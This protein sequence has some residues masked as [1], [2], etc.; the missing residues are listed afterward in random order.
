MAPALDLLAFGRRRETAAK[1]RRARRPALKSLESRQLLS[2][3][4]VADFPVKTASSWPTG[5]TAG[6]D[7]NLWFTENVSGGKVGEIN[8]T[9]HAVTEFPIPTT[10]SGPLGITAGPDGNLWFTEG[11]TDKIGMINPTTHAITE[12]PVPTAKS[13]PDGI[14]AGPDGE[15]W[16]TEQQADKIGMIDPTTPCH[17]RVHH[18]DRQRG[19]RWESRPGPTATSGSP[20][21]PG[22]QDRHDQP[23][24]PR[25]HRVRH[26]DHRFLA[27][28]GS[29]PG[30]M[31]TSGSPRSATDRDDQPDDPCH[32]R[33]RRPRSQVHPARD[34]GRSRRQPLVHRGYYQQGRDDQSDHP[35]HRR[36][37]DPDGEP[38][39][40]DMAAGPDGNLWFTEVL[41]N[42]IG[43]VTLATHLIATTQPPQS[44][45]PGTPFTVTVALTYDTGLVDTAYNG[46]VTIALAVN[47][48]GATLGGM[49]TATAKNGV[50]TFSGL[51]LDKEGTGYRLMAYTDPLTATLTDPVTVATPPTIVTEKVLMTGRGRRRRVVGF[52][53]DFSKSLDPATA[54]NLANYVLTQTVKRRRQTILQR[55]GF[56]VVYNDATRSV[57]L[58][59]TGRAKFAQGGQLVVEAGPPDGITDTTGTYLD[60]AGTGVPGGNGVFTISTRARSITRA[61]GPGNPV[62]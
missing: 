11:V 44:A 45:A 14:T 17:H 36:V 21:A 47:P 2:S 4:T 32:H 57:S 42:K 50:A 53:L 55:M 48:G 16:F 51:T 37:R 20:R 40:G 5:I 60:G 59:L 31:A 38:R 62:T 19:S 41:G 24:D 13:G 22:R 34:R 7:G 12:F 15:L 29:R 3:I 8:P 61:M 39:P 9:T 30:P 10:N 49:L 6:P 58:M 1:R 18:P 25:H 27:P 52:E 28:P 43:V 56:Q 54:Q 46:P 23:D 33:V 26:P 35:R